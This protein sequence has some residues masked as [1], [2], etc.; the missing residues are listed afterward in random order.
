MT[1]GSA[2]DSAGAA[3]PERA[4][5]EAGAHERIAHLAVETPDAVHR[6]GTV[7]IVGRPNVGKSSLLNALIGQKLSITSPRPQTTRHRVLGIRTEARAQLIF[8]DS[9]GWQS[10]HR[11]PIHRL[12]NRTAEQ[13]A[14]EADLVLWVVEACHAPSEDGQVAARIA[15]GRPV[16][17]V[18]NKVDRVRRKEKVFEQAAALAGRFAVEAVVPVSA[19]RSTQ[20][21]ALVGECIA[22]LPPGPAR[23]PVDA[24]TDCS[25]RFLAGELVREKLFRLLGDE[26]PYETTVLVERF[27]EP[28]AARPLRRIHALIVVQRDAQRAIVLGHEGRAIRRIGSEARRDMERLFGG[29]VY[30]GLHVKVRSDWAAQEQALRAYGYGA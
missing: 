25:E 8:I 21:D 10:V 2:D 12:L 16:I 20:L 22:R 19:L 14:Q 15:P 28:V 5:R 29:R 18:I 30:L 7:A 27:E 1:P 26:L 11:E 13:V 9:P 4:A 17:L 3:A 23:Y 6:C 24:L